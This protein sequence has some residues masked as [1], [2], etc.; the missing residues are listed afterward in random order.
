MQSL[1]QRI[2]QP[3]WYKINVVVE[4]SICIGTY[5]NEEL[6]DF[7]LPSSEH[8]FVMLPNQLSALRPQ[9]NGIENTY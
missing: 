2:N 5:K 9:E 7:V 6:V 4:C 3:E 8:P 1:L